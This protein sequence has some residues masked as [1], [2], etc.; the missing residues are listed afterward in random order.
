MVG[1][2]TDLAV[3]ISGPASKAEGDTLDYTVTITNNG[4]N[5]ATGVVLTDTLG[6][7]LR[8]VS[9]VVPTGVTNNISGNV[10]TFSFGSPIAA[11]GS[12]TLT[13]S[14]QA[15]E[16]G[17]TANTASCKTTASDSN[18]N[19]NSAVATT[20]VAE[21]LI[22]VSA[23]ITSTARRLSSFAVATFTHA[24]GIEPT[25]AFVATIDWGDRSTSTGA[26]VL[27]G[28]TYT[29]TG[30]HRY[31]SSSTHT[32]TTK[33]VEI[34]AAAELLLLKVGDEVPD[35]PTRLTDSHDHD[36]P[37]LNR[38]TNDFAKSVDAYLGNFGNGSSGAGSSTG[39]KPK[40]SDLA[41]SVSQLLKRGKSEGRSVQLGALLT[42]LHARD[43]AKSSLNEVLSMLDD[44]FPGS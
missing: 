23:P 32:I 6:S 33:V 22:V 40:L 37:S 16:D 29:V 38:Q 20:T 11:G 15:I 41:D 4:S 28:T 8:Y 3:S 9:S 13:I 42:S 2:E 10:L 17:A 21:P 1:P 14:A 26:I 30:S 27:S 5:P 39:A 25:N 34:G 18:L 31:S 36:C 35:L 7:G 43:S 19:N 12:A 44:V 24:N